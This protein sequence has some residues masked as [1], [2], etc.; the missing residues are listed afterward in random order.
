MVRRPSI[1][2]GLE[3]FRT[4]RNVKKCTFVN[5]SV[6]SLTSWAG[7]AMKAAWDP[8]PPIPVCERRIARYSEGLYRNGTF[9]PVSSHKRM[10]R[11]LSDRR[12][13]TTS[14]LASDLPSELFAGMISAIC[15][16]FTFVRIAVESSRQSRLCAL[17][18]RMSKCSRKSSPR[19]PECSSRR[20]EAS[21]D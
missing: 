15:A 17:S 11:M 20:S 3:P 13:S 14:A 10:G 18:I 2:V 7:T 6:P 9:E 5:W 21:G 4:S 19:T 12:D 16:P 8:S 1:P